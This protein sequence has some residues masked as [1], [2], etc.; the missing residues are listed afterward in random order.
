[1]RCI[2]PI[3]KYITCQERPKLD[4]TQLETENATL[5]G[6]YLVRVQIPPEDT[7]RLLAAITQIT[8]LRYG[9]CESVSFRSSP[10]TLQF[11]ALEGSIEGHS[12]LYQLPGQQVSFT[13]PGE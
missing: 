10:G 4:I 2:L 9:R 5:Q 6:E 11:K 8:P 12:E 3:P 1:M 7:P 13:L